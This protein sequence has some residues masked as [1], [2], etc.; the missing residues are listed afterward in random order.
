MPGAIDWRQLH[1]EAF[2]DRPAVV[3]GGAG[4]IGSHLVNALCDLGARVII[5]DD[6]SSGRAQNVDPRAALVQASILDRNA[7][8]DA[9]AGARYVFHEAA[10]VSVPASVNDPIRYHEVNVNGTLY[11]LTAAQK[12]GV[13]RV[14]F[15][16]SSSA[17]GDTAE[18]PKHEKMPPLSKSPYAANKVASEHLMRAFANSY[19]IDAVSLRYFN[20]FGPRQVANSPYSGVIAKFASQLLAGTRPTITGDGSATRD[21]TFVLNAVHANLLAARHDGPLKGDVFNVCT[22][23]RL[24]ILHLAQTMARLIDRPDLAPEFLPPRP[25]DVLDSQGD[26]GLIRDTLGYGVI[27][28]F[29]EGIA[30]TLAWYRSLA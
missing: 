19:P 14:V 27:V 20:I 26:L 13:K 23:E 16:A 4:F 30:Q 28:P 7:L 24:S 8:A 1:G 3:T 17:Y 11:V 10:L 18:L 25:G 2:A 5:I 12:A 29:E 15:A 6:F 21:F 9:M 22:G